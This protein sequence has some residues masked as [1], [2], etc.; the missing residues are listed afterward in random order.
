[1]FVRRNV[2]DPTG[3]FGYGTFPYESPVLVDPLDPTGQKF[4]Y[5]GA[6][7]IGDFNGDGFPDLIVGTDG[8]GYAMILY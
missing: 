2:K 4:G 3:T 6:M 8:A 5:F 7:P 1:V